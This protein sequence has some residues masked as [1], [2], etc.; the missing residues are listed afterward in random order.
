MSVSY[1]KPFFFPLV[2]RSHGYLRSVPSPLTEEVY[3]L[4]SWVASSVLGAGDT[5]D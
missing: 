3:Q 1:L 2:G 5:G 4:H